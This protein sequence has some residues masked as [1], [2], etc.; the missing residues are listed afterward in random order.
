[1]VD[2]WFVKSYREPLANQHLYQAIH[3]HSTCIT[4][5]LDEPL[6][7]PRRCG[8]VLSR[9]YNDLSELL[10]LKVIAECTGSRLRQFEH[11]T[12]SFIFYP[13]FKEACAVPGLQRNDAELVHIL[14]EAVHYQIPFQY[15][16]LPFCPTLRL[17]YAGKSATAV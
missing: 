16:L 11:T 12:I 14:T 4:Q 13:T 1:M 2:E 5:G 3:M 17:Q 15:Q 9:M 10:K 7:R 6:W 8:Q